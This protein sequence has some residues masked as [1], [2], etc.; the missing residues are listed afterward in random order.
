MGKVNAMSM[1]HD[2]RVV[3][4]LRQAIKYFDFNTPFSQD[5]DLINAI[6]E[7]LTSHNFRIVVDY[8]CKDSL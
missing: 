8:T 1:E 4:C 3:A 5:E 2:D 7:A 6:L